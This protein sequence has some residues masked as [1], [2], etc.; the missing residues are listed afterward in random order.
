[1]DAL[2]KVRGE[3]AVIPLINSLSDSNWR[4]VRSAINSL[5]NYTDSLAKDKLLEMLD[6]KNPEQT[7]LAA[8]ALVRIGNENAIDS[9]IVYAE[10]NIISPN[11]N[12]IFALGKRKTKEAEKLL[13]KYFY[14]EESKIREAAVIA[15]L[16]YKTE[17]IINSLTK[18]LKDENWEVRLYSE[19]VL[20]IISDK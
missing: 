14:N 1:M 3:S 18:L 11:I 6:A 20:K 15:A 16:N 13:T 5:G 12:L 10:Q 9:I 7:S 4:V 17:S 2:G 19:E 8:G